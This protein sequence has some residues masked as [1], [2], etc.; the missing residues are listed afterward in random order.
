M[1]SVATNRLFFALLPSEDVRSACHKACREL[2]MKMS[3]TGR[4][5]PADN[6]HLTLLFLGSTVSDA[7]EEKALE[8]AESVSAVPFEFTLDIAQ[9]FQ[10][11]NVWWLGPRN[12]PKELMELRQ[13]LYRAVADQGIPL[14]RNRFIP[15]VSVYRGNQKLP[16]T[17]I[18][19]FT[20]ASAHFALMR[21]HIEPQG[22][23]YEVVRTLPL[24]TSEP[25]G[26]RQFSLWE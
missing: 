10:E 6:Y 4:P 5:I 22:S 24:R 20:W 23:R 15:H 12:P 11:A 8:A 21:S 18:K 16:P 7:D 3:P 9:S 19:P 26:K 2:Q 14:D 25:H 17:Q 1:S 13:N